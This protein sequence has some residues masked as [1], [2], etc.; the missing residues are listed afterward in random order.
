MGRQQDSARRVR[1]SILKPAETSWKLRTTSDVGELS[2]LDAQRQI[3][4]G[5]IQIHELFS[6]LAARRHVSVVHKPRGRY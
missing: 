5:G 2:V 3:E 4:N 6:I 1:E